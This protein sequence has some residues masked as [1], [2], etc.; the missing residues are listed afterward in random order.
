MLAGAIR[1]FPECCRK[2][3]CANG[4]SE[5]RLGREQH[6]PAWRCR[7]DCTA[8]HRASLTPPTAAAAVHVTLFG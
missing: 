1:Q 6:G 4:F 3:L 8:L 2:W 5:K 7:A